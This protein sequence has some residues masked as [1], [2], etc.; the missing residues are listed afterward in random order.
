MNVD[1]FGGEKALEST[2]LRD[3]I[4]KL[5]SKEKYKITLYIL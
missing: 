3:K 4:K 1:I 2:K 5:L